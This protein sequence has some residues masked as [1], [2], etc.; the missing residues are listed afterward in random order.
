MQ[1]FMIEAGAHVAFSAE[2]Q[3]RAADNAEVFRN[4]CSRQLNLVI[5]DYGFHRALLRF[6]LDYSSFLAAVGARPRLAI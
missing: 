3:C 2:H 1:T 6:P 5:S 4:R